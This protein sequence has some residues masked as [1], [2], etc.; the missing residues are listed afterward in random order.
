M[1][2]FAAFRATMRRPHYSRRTKKA[3]FHWVLRKI[4]TPKPGH[5]V[6]YHIH[7]AAIQTTLGHRRARRTMT[8]THVI[9]RGPLGFISR[10]NR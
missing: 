1:T 2:L 7:D 3:H 9:N 4:P 10:L 8:Y 5:A 6:R